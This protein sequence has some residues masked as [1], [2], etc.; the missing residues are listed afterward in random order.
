M[1]DR[2]YLEV[3]VEQAKISVEQDGFPAGAVIVKDGKIISKG[4]SLGFIFHDPTSHAETAA[5][6]EACK[7]LKT[8]NLDGATLYENLACCIMCF[9]VA[10][11]AGIFKIVSGCRKTEDMVSKGYYEGKTDVKKL[12]EEF[13]RKMELVTL[14]DFEKESLEL[15]KKWE[16]DI[17]F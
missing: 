11:W 7:M 16:A 10:N 6:R 9:S 15:I 5:I 17:R 1:T 2:D 14:L 13:S 3:A 12:N 8:S 4:I